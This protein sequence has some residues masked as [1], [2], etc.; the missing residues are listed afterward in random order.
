MRAP[1][2]SLNSGTA[3]GLGTTRSGSHRCAIGRTAGLVPG[4]KLRRRKATPLRQV[5]A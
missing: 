4:G 1:P 2:A 5:S 3:S